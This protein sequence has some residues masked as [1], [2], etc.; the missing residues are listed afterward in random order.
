MEIRYSRGV[1]L[2]KCGACYA[3]FTYLGASGEPVGCQ[4]R[5]DC[6]HG[7]SDSDH[8]DRALINIRNGKQ[9]YE[10][11]PEIA[12]GYSKSQDALLSLGQAEAKCICRGGRHQEK[13]NLCRERIT[14]R[15]VDEILAE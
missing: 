8:N 10:R 14:S 15:G 7:K 1:P 4:Q 2:L 13:Q 11:C 6:L 12:R 5:R 3:R 9:R